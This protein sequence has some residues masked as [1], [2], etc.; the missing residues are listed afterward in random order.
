MLSFK[1][2]IPKTKKAGSLQPVL[3]L[4]PLKLPTTDDDKA[5]FITFELKTR[6][7]AAN[8]STK[9]KKHCK[10]FDEGTPQD[11]ID[12]LRDFNEIWTQ[13]S[14]NGGQ[15]RAATVRALIA[16]ESEVAFDAAFL[17]VRTA[18]DGTVQPATSEHVAAALKAVTKTVFPH[19][20]L[21]IQK[22]WMTRKMFKPA[23]LST[24]Q[25]AAAINRLNNALP[26]F[27]GGDEDSKFSTNEVVG[28]L[29]WA[30]PPAW[31]A[32]FDLDGYVPTSDTKARLIEACEA[33]ERN[34]IATK[35]NN[36]KNESNNKKNKKDGKSSFRTK[37]RGQ[38]RSA[39]DDSNYFC[40]EHGPNHTHDTAD[41]Y[42]LKNKANKAKFGQKE[43]KSK[44][45]SNKNF[46]KE[47][48]LMA[49]SSSKKKVLD[50]YASAIKREQGKLTKKKAKKSER[51]P[52]IDSESDSDNSV[53]VVSDPKPALKKQLKKALKKNNTVLH[54]EEEEA[55]QK[56]VKWLADHGDQPMDE[57]ESVDESDDASTSD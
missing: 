10:K 51:E 2:R 34:E 16:G 52:D 21:E 27:P 26:L 50:L 31:R 8:D 9:Y 5:K 1:D 3:P 53:H 56:R 19:R 57:V 46:R 45:F 28:L 55:Y 54:N 20:A 35:D 15:D 39:D 38:K 25:T 6:V 4:V 49:K 29:E 7:G 33:I 37:K 40:K 48:N 13:N 24:R 44:T 18:E 30:L 23:E 41:C 14:M 36:N 22:L 47:I 12:V 42:T 32:K 11:W 43:D 17:E